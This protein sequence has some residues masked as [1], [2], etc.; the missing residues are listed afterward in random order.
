MKKMLL[1]CPKFMNYDE[2]LLDYLK[3]LYVIKYVNTEK[4]L[5][6]NR[7]KYKRIPIIFRLF[8]K[9]FK[10]IRN[11][12][13]EHLLSLSDFEFWE[14]VKEIKNYDIILVING[15]GI[16]DNI[17]KKIILNNPDAKKYLYIWDDLYLLFK[18]SHIKYFDKVSS[19]NI[20]DCKKINATYQPVFTKKVEV[21]NYEKK[22]D[23]SIIATA[24]K[25]RIKIAKSIYEKYKDKYRFFIYFY[26]KNKNFDFF[27]YEQ[28]LKY[29]EYQIIL[30]QSIAILDNGRYKQKGPTTRVFDTIETKTKVITTNKN[31]V[32]YPVFGTN[33][34][35]IDN[36]YNIPNKFIKSEYI[37]KEIT[38]TITV[39]LWL[40]NVIDL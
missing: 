37:D 7:E 15:D 26:D 24:T 38:F 13:R 29:S 25:E 34:L 36:K 14:E 22:Y 31:I 4:Y 32:K 35:I 21:N 27:C 20:D 16:S 28:P 3:D 2:I 11:I 6:P 19:Y 33:I 39:D 12:M 9:C 5:K 17:Y 1:L 8:L 23:I 30:A 18:K 10:P 40:K